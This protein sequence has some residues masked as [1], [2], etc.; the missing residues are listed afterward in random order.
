MHI[1]TLLP[2]E[3][4][5]SNLC[6]LSPLLAYPCTWWSATDSPEVADVA[7][8]ESLISIISADSN[9]S[10]HG[11]GGDE[12]PDGQL[13]QAINRMSSVAKLGQKDDDKN[14]T[15]SWTFDYQE[16]ADL[17][18]STVDD[19]C[20]S[21]D[22][23]GDAIRSHAGP[24]MNNVVRLL[25]EFQ[26]SVGSLLRKQSQPHART[27]MFRSYSDSGLFGHLASPGQLD[28][29]NR[30]LQRSRRVRSATSPPMPTTGSAADP[31][32][33]ALSSFWQWLM[34]SIDEQFQNELFGY[35]RNDSPRLRNDSVP[36]LS[37]GS[38]SS[39]ER[40]TS[41]QDED[42]DEGAD[43]WYSS[44]VPLNGR[45]SSDK[46]A[47]HKLTLASMKRIPVTAT[48]GTPSPLWDNR[49]V[50]EPYERSWSSVL[51]L[52]SM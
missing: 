5:P 49:W 41:E 51:G 36:S 34:P 16:E 2:L 8:S 50:E 31:S 44:D 20:K 23:D 26:P 40:G 1:D 39:S 19:E 18:G 24:L 28:D 35:P 52:S 3:L 12:D 47:L 9:G 7:R 32:M 21:D 13:D 22:G 46:A 6:T 30:K 37:S 27:L 38:V 42:E 45:T 25:L 29:E 48:S 4:P 14:E 10:W 33:S 11:D 17:L 15:E 43:Q